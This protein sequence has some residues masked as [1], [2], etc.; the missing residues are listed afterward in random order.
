[1]FPL[2]VNKL[3][4]DW[5]T[6]TALVVNK[7]LPK[8]RS[9]L[10]VYLASDSV[11]IPLALTCDCS[12]SEREQHFRSTNNVPLP[13]WTTDHLKSTAEGMEMMQLCTMSA[14]SCNRSAKLKHKCK[15]QIGH[16]HFQK[17]HMF[18]SCELLTCN[19]KFCSNLV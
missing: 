9:K 13:L 8:Q 16:A 10:Q 17:F 14:F 12:A 15:L 4:D 7:S 6:L 1:M 19:N 5:K 18:I 11:Q 2:L 3:W